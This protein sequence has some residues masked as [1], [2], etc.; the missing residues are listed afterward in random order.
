MPYQGISCGWYVGHSSLLVFSAGAMS[1]ALTINELCFQ[2]GQGQKLAGAWN[3]VL[4]REIFR[5]K[6]VLGEFC[7]GLTW[8]SRNDL[9]I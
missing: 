4:P 3:R 2:L 8:D 6:K 7:L 1:H 9:Q 5:V